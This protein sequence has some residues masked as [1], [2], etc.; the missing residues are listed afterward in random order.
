MSRVTS[1]ADVNA[2]A[3]VDD[4]E[5]PWSSFTEFF[6]AR[7]DLDQSYLTELDHQAGARREWTVEQWRGRVA[8]TAAALLALGVKPGDSVA[9][10]AGNSSDALALAYACWTSGSCYVPLNPHEPLERH[11]YIVRDAQA[12]FLVHSGAWAQQAA[13]VAAV[14]SARPVG[15]GA[16]THGGVGSSAPPVPGPDSAQ[17]SL[18]SPALRVYTSGTTGEPKGV[19]LSARNLLTDCDG[20]MQGLRWESDTRILTV[21]PVHHVNGLVISSLLPWYAGFSTVLTDRFRSGRFWEDVATEAATVCSVV[22]SLLEFLLTDE[23]PAT[24]ECFREMLC[25]AG[26]LMPQTVGEFESTSGVPVRHL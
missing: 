21:L 6:Q 15:T 19:V 13:E 20:L 10:L 12:A 7:T 1:L 9:A 26:P 5:L 3:P 25:G 24:P 11:A 17:L 23:Q 8:E 16:L 18:D 2:S 14:T 4:F 22:P